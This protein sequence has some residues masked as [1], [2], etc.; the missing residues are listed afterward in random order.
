MGTSMRLLILMAALAALAGCNTVNG[1]GQDISGG[2]ET[3]Q[4]WF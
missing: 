4:D 1:V 3:V 2:A